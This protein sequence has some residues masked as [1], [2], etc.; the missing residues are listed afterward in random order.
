MGTYAQHL[1]HLKA[2]KDQY[3]ACCAIFQYDEKQSVAKF[4]GITFEKLA[5]MECH[6]WRRIANRY[7]KSLD[8]MYAKA[9]LQGTEEERKTGLIFTRFYIPKNF[10]RAGVP[11]ALSIE[12]G[13]L[14]TQ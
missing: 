3:R 10:C 9:R 2:L 5:N 4:Y 14:W 1:A 12:K 6:R 13:V 7:K 8:Q 11:Q